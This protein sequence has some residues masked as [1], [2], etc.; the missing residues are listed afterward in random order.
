MKIYT[1][2]EENQLRRLLEGNMIY[3]E[4]CAAGVDNWVGCNF[5][6]YPDEDEIEAE[7]NKFGNYVKV[8]EEDD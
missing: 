5:I 6:H 4:L 2:V 3:E 1:L 8:I 7:L